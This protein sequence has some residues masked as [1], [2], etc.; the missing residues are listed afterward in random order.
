MRQSAKAMT[1]TA[2]IAF[3]L[4]LI[5]FTSV[6]SAAVGGTRTQN[7]CG[8][9]TLYEQKFRQNPTLLSPDACPTYGPCD[10]PVTRD[11]WSAQGDEPIVYVRLYFHVFAET[12][13]SNP[14]ATPADVDSQVNAL[15][16]AYLPHRIQFVYEMRT[17]NS[18]Q[19][20]WLT[21]SNEFDAM[22]T[23]YNI[24]PSQQCNIYVSDVNVDGQVYSYG[25]FPWDPDALGAHGG[26][27]MNDSQFWPLDDG[28]L[29]HE[30]GHN[31]GL[32]HT[33]HGVSEVT[34]CSD[35][36][37]SPNGTNR[38]YNGDFCSDTDP[39]PVNYQCEPPGGTDPCSGLSWG[40]TD[41]QNYMSYAPSYCYEEFSPQQSGRLRCW[42]HNSLVTWALPVTW[43]SDT[44]LGPA[45]LTVSFQA[46]SPRTVSAWNWTFG[47]GGTSTVQNP[48]HQYVT[49]GY[50]NVSLSITTPQGIV[51][52]T[53]SGMESIYA[54]SLRIDTVQCL[55][56]QAVHVD[57]YLHNH[58][59]IKEITIPFTWAG[60]LNLVFDSISTVGLRTD[61][62]EVKSIAGYQYSLKRAAVYLDATG[63]GTGA[64]LT[65]G[66]GS[67][68]S[69]WFSVPSNAPGGVNPIALTD[70]LSYR[71][72]LTTYAGSYSP[73]GR[74]G[75][76]TYRRTCCTGP[77]RGNIDMSPD[78]LV[79]MS[80]LTLLID[81]LFITL[82]ALPCDDA[83]NVDLSPDEMITMSDLT[84]LIDHLFITLAP[85]PPCP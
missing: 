74:S 57:V 33:H 76:A 45:P 64:Y 31:L 43:G 80:D 55:P 49:P 75:S 77:S 19:Y 61:F 30:M 13:G 60:P 2:V 41:P 68:V 8:T 42:L 83:A 28:T 4:S 29:P 20:R 16:A 67:V 79:T 11:S 50:Y 58:L 12:D 84:V 24:S 56:G 6:A 5:A 25:T 63:S 1:P 71:L 27:V 69:L 9:Q 51:S 72:L 66:S 59:P 38:D 81:H 32:W 62:F 14:A 47:D 39:T 85:L 26:I 37:E 52:E 73:Y 70:F 23:A 65:A 17:I 44:A 18:T 34:Q 10:N 78:Y 35:C 15:N 40:P 22:K 82:A 21:A 3:L 36:W 53:K 46:E 48:T 7:W 54:D